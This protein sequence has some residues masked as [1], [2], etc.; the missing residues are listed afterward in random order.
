MTRCRLHPHD[1]EDL[2]GATHRRYTGIKCTLARSVPLGLCLR[3]PMRPRHGG[4]HAGATPQATCILAALRRS[5][6]PTPA[7]AGAAG[8]DGIELKDLLWRL[9]R[10]GLI[11]KAAG[12]RPGTLATWEMAP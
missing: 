6:L 4:K 11:R 9:S 3:E 1:A 7:L 10:A 12:W 2:R 8:L 5:P